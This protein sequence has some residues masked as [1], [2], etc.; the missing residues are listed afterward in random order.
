MS[1]Q[2]LFIYDGECPFC[3]HFAELLELKSNLPN[4]QV[5][6]ARNNPSEIPKGYDMDRNGA[7]LISEGKMLFGADAI[8]Y[9]SSRIKDPSDSLL[10]LLT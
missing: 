4:I 7:I 1:N 2:I 9:I 8:N 6:N 5:K 3:N 10:K